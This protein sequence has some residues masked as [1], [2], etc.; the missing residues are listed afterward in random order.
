MKET[1]EADNLKVSQYKK[2]LQVSQFGSKAMGGRQ[3]R[4]YAI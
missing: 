4:V 1:P 2:K 3:R